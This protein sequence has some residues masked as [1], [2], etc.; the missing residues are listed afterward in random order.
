M[1]D[2]PPIVAETLRVHGTLYPDEREELVARWSKLDQ[3]LQSFAEDTITLDLHVHDRDTP[4]QHVILDVT[5]AHYPRFVA[6]ARDRRLD[7]ALNVVRDEIIRQ[8]TDAKSK[9]E[10]AHSKRRRVR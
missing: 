10:P 9:R 2:H 3:R 7:H 4:D 5:V 1:S 6:T 8:L